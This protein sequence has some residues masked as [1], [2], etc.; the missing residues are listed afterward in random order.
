MGD[1]RLKPV[2]QDD[3]IRLKWARKFRF[4]NSGIKHDTDDRIAD[5]EII[6]RP[7][8]PSKL[9][10]IEDS[11]EMASNAQRIKEN[12]ERL[13]ELSKDTQA[14]RDADE[15]EELGVGEEGLSEN[16]EEEEQERSAKRRKIRSE[17]P[18]PLASRA[19][20]MEPTPGNWA[21]LH[22][23]T[24]QLV[25]AKSLYLLRSG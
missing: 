18:Q 13:L 2:K 5:V 19:D 9:V 16:G 6:H 1:G 7:R 24:M 8:N 12:L 15:S 10:H 4:C 3:L 11:N 17:G 22:E 23:W 25:C 20:Q 21:T 14:W